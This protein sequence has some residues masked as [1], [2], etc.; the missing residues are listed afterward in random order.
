M[1]PTFADNGDQED[2]IMEYIEKD[3]NYNTL[4][5]Y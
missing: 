5:V 2:W 1:D 4:L 3:S